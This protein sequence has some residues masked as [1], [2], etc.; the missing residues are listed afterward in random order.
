MDDAAAG[1]FL[2]SR[3]SSVATVWSRDEPE[4]CLIQ[5]SEPFS[6]PNFY[7]HDGNIYLLVIGLFFLLTFECLL[8]LDGIIFHDE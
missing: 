2:H 5:D 4:L 6:F 1:H 8:N 3:N 7:C